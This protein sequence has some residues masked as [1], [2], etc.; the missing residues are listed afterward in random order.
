MLTAR[1]FS[2]GPDGSIA[3]LRR[4][5]LRPHEFLAH[6]DEFLGGAGMDADGLVERP[7][8]RAAFDRDR[9]ALDDFRRVGSEHVA[10]ENP[11]ALAVDHQLH[12]GAL[13]AAR[14]R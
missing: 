9:E 10:A 14:Q 12:E 4:L 7:L 6:R 11:V 8:R 13:V 1:Y 2:R 3:L 5:L